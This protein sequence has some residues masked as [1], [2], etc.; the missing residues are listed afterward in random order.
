MPKYFGTDG[1]RA[2]AG[3]FPLVEDFIVKLAYCALSEAQKQ[4]HTNGRAKTV[5]MAEDSRASGPQ[6]AQAL[7]RGIRAAGYNVLHIGIAPTPAVSYLTQKYNA[8]AG[9]VISASHNPAE[10]NGIKF[11]SPAGTKLGE[12]I[13]AAIE[14]QIDSNPQIPAPAANTAF[15][16]DEKPQRDYMDFLKSTVPAGAN[17][18][19]V[20]IVLDC[21]NGAAYKI[22]PQVFSELGAQITVINNTPDGLNINKDAGALHTQAMQQKTKD[23]GSFIGFSF[24]GDA[25]RLIA[26]DEAGQQLDGDDIIT[27]AALHLKQNNKLTKDKVVLTVMANLGLI[28]FLKSRGISPAL[29]QVGDKYVFEELAKDNLSLGGETS[30]HVIFRDIFSAGD[31]I[32]AAIQLLGIILL[33]GKKPSY[34]KTLW[35]RYPLKLTALKVKTKVPLEDIEGFLPLVSDLEKQMA[36]KGRTVIRYSGT[37]PVLRILVEGESKTQVEEISQKLKEFYQ[38]KVETI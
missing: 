13:E 6:I 29:T 28:N 30:G 10:F 36:G 23:T 31:G 15:T 26:S 18:K 12:E 35:Q 32:L 9:V 5:I 7:Q 8:A 22:A 34:Y 4:G 20:K 1:V 25:D 24:D 37:E 16:R 27:A 33:D 19:D 14:A 17:F 38:S 2:V 3:Q 21:A 11:F